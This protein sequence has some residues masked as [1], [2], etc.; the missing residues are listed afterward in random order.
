MVE[1]TRQVQSEDPY[2]RF[3]EAINDPRLYEIISI[4]AGRD[5]PEPRLRCRTTR[6]RFFWPNRIRAIEEHYRRVPNILS[7]ASRRKTRVGSR[8]V[9]GVLALS[10]AA[11]ILALFPIDSTRAVIVNAKASLANAAP[12]PFGGAQPDAAAP[13]P[14]VAAP[15]GEYRTGRSA[16][17]QPPAASSPAAF[18]SASPS[19]D[20]ITAAYQTAIK[21]QVVAVEPATRRSCRPAGKAHRSG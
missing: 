18:A 8:I 3:D 5:L 11:A 20:E 13:A 21:S 7:D 6:F 10:A 1:S 16:G 19:R 14:H 9:T 12:A 4:S 2:D 15:A 17:A